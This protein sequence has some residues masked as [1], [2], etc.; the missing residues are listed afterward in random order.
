MG[1][2]LDII[3][4]SLKL[5]NV[6][7]TGEAPDADDANDGL[8]ALNGIIQSC[9]NQR[10]MLYAVKNVTGTLT[11]NQT[12]HTVGTGGNINIDRPLRIEKAFVR[13][14]GLTNPI[15]YPLEQD[16]NNRFQEYTVKYTKVSYPTNFYYEPSYPLATIYLYPI[17]SQTL[18]LHLSVWNQITEFTLLTTAASLPMNY[19][20]F[21]VY[22]LACDLAIEHGRSALVV[23][24]SP[25]KQRLAE[26]KKEIKAVNQP[27]FT[28]RIDN[29]VLGKR[30]GNQAFNIYR[31]Y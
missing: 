27:K 14:P 1:T 5:I 13:V 11:A 8:K 28:S 17:Q 7:Q 20:N 3:T 23:D 4:R 18:E 21:L 26:F 25:I 6:L 10:L 19:E 30:L 9:N 2:A 29:A 24:G 22:Q 12:Y 15:D 31:G 16:D